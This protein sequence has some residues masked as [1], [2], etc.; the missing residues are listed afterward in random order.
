LAAPPVRVSPTARPN[1]KRRRAVVC[2]FGGRVALALIWNGRRFF[3][4]DDARRSIALRCWSGRSAAVSRL[5]G[6]GR[7]LWAQIG[8]AGRGGCSCKRGRRASALW[9]VRGA[10]EPIAAR[11]SNERRRRAGA[12]NGA[13]SQSNHLAAYESE[14]AHCDSRPGKHTHRH[15]S[16]SLGLTREPGRDWQ[17][18]SIREPP[19]MGC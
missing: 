1:E 10:A 18:A 19:L 9:A 14:P 2:L 11:F 7:W 12:L 5:H 8:G 13:H 6:P 4:P 16:S 3:S 17:P 15:Y